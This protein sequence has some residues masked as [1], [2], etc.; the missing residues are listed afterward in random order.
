M[1]HDSHAQDVGDDRS[2]C[3]V[4]ESF[5]RARFV[6]NKAPDGEYALG[7]DVR[8]IPESLEFWESSDIDFPLENLSFR[9]KAW[10]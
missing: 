7:F 4:T 3:N 9:Q 1:A 10:R 8:R 6:S 2:Q 5:C